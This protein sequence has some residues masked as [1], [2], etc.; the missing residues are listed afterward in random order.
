MWIVIYKSYG[1]WKTTMPFK[2]EDKAR[3]HAELYLMSSVSNGDKSYNT[4]IEFVFLPQM[5]D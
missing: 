5:Q 4:K 1:E 3:K 2:T